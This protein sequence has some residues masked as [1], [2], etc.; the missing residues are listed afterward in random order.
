MLSILRLRSG[1]CPVLKQIEFCGANG[2]WLQAV[3]EQEQER[4]MEPSLQ[5]T[6]P[7]IFVEMGYNYR[8][9]R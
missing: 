2:G 3:I 1:I 4:S 8:G 9:V 6:E 7:Q 5:F